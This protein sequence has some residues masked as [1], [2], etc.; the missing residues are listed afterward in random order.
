MASQV[1]EFPKSDALIP[2]ATAVLD[3]TLVDPDD[4]VIVDAAIS[5]IR[6]TLQDLSVT[7]AIINSRLNQDAHNTGIGEVTDGVLTLSLTP[8]DTQLVPGQSKPY[9]QR[10]LTITVTYSG[11]VLVIVAYFWVRNPTFT[12]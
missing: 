5:G 9:Q 2:G 3:F 8:A 7:G 4:A 10:L 6:I 11:G 12:R 1:I